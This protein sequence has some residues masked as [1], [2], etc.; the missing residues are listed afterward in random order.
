MFNDRDREA[1]QDIALRRNQHIDTRY[2][3]YEQNGQYTVKSA[4]K[5]LQRALGRWTEDEENK[6]WR[7][8]WKL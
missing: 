2:W 4:Y 5:M 6:L 7:G 8:L 3:C 1:I